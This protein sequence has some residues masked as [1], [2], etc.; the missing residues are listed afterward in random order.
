MAIAFHDFAHVFEVTDQPPRPERIR[1]YRPED[2]GDSWVNDPDESVVLNPY[3]SIDFGTQRPPQ[4]PG[5]SSGLVR[6]V[7]NP[8]V[9]LGLVLYQIGSS[10]AVD[11]QSGVNGVKH[12]KV[13]VMKSLHK[14]DE[15]CNGSF[16]EVVQTCLDWRNSITAPVEK[17]DYVWIDRIRHWLRVQEE[18][19]MGR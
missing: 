19:L 9:E 8:V 4:L 13:N 12:A 7:V 3:L 1:Y 6:Q 18:Q 5:I 11:Y 16:T 15:M 17:G 10:D 2:E 14:L